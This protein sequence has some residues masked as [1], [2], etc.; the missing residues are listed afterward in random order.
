MEP[1]CGFYFTCMKHAEGELESILLYFN[2]TFAMIEL[3]I[4]THVNMQLLMVMEQNA[5]F[6]GVEATS[7]GFYMSPM[8]WSICNRKCCHIFWI[9]TSCTSCN[10]PLIIV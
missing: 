7:L 6:F 5:Y 8:R 4:L 9:L 10:C 1:L 2:Y 3:S